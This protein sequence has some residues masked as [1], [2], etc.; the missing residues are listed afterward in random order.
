[1]RARDGHRRIF[2][3]LA[4]VLAI[5]LSPRAEGRHWRHH[6]RHES[7]VTGGESIID[8]RGNAPPNQDRQ[9]RTEAP[10]IQGRQGSNVPPQIHVRQG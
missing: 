3:T 6:E 8:R 9:A 5:C 7:P 10:R 4:A 2:F 1:M